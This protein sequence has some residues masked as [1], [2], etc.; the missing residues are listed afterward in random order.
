MKVITRYL[1]DELY[2]AENE[3]GNTIN[4]D[5]RKA[6]DKKSLA[7]IEIMLASIAGCA[8]VDIVSMLKKKRKTFVDLTVETTGVRRDEHPRGLTHITSKYT[9]IS[10]DT[11]LATFEK[12]AIMATHKYCSAAA[13]VK[14]EIEIECEVFESK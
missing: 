14:A 5:M 4:I 8:A 9:L 7:P 3:N 12:V 1:E 6:E 13:S 11:N 2:I 10:P